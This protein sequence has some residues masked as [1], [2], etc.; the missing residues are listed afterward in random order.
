MDRA[1]L[2]R[3]IDAYVR[4]WRTAGTDRL[5]EIF[6]E[7]AAYSAGPFE[8]LVR[9]LP[10]IAEFWEAERVDADEKFELRSEVLAV[11]GD[12][13]VARVEVRYGP[14]REQLY[15]DLWVVRMD[16]E[17]RCSRFEEWP[18]WPPGTGGTVA[19]AT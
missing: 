7:D 13:G 8:D 2:Q 6:A 1:D 12:T 17:G 11:E 16:A 10:A 9:G 5:G 3:W 19:G 14:P 4:L 18:F 15:R